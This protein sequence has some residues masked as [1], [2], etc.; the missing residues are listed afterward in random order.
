MTKIVHQ[1][2]CAHLPNIRSRLPLSSALTDNTAL[3]THIR[4]SKECV[5]VHAN[6]SGQTQHPNPTQ[7]VEVIQT[8]KLFNTPLQGFVEDEEV[9]LV[10]VV[11]VV[12]VVRVV[13]VRVVVVVC[14]A[15]KL[16]VDVDDRIPRLL[17]VLVLGST[18]RVDE[19]VLAKITKVVLELGSAFKVE[20]VVDGKTTKVVLT[21][22]VPT[23]KIVLVESEPDTVVP[24]IPPGQ[25][26]IPPTSVE[27]DSE[28]LFSKVVAAAEIEV[29]DTDEPPSPKVTLPPA[30]TVAPTPPPPVAEA[31][32]S[33]PFEPVLTPTATLAPTDSDTLPV[34]VAWTPKSVL[35]EAPTPAP[36]LAP[37]I[38]WPVSDATTHA[39]NR[40]PP[41]VQVFTSRLLVVTPAI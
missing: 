14:C 19:V 29:K 38:P 12:V 20:E 24:K 21:E 35:L 28:A 5:Y 10:P 27:Q 40:S 13:V 26:T 25:V 32:R 33:I 39:F 1:R 2:L 11:V 4:E 9:L 7:S 17:L 22:L 34:P 3:H 41:F 30:P 15:S 16:L 6:H 8:P 37:T 36:A 23:C 18:F 31:P